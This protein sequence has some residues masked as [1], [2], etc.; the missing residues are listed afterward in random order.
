MKSEEKL[1]FA[2][3]FLAGAAIV[4]LVFLGVYLVTEYAQEEAVKEEQLPLTDVEKVYI[5]RIEFSEPKVSR[6]ANFLNQEVTF[7]FGNVVNHGPRAIRQM[8]LTLEFRDAFGQVVLRDVRRPW[9]SQATPL[10][11]SQSREFQLTFEYVP[12]SWNQAYPGLRITG[13]LLE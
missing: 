10:A 7:V 3:S 1:S 11:G 2:P 12:A 8:E 13:L 5:G 6:A 4:L 9:A